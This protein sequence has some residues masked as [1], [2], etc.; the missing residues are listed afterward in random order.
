MSR[1]QKILVG[2]FIALLAG[3]VYVEATA[4]QPINWFPSYAKEDKI[5]LGGFV[6]DRLLKESFGDN[7]REIKTPPFETLQEH[8]FSGSYLFVNDEIDFDKTERDS[9][10][11]W[12]AKGNTVFVSAN[13]L[14]SSLLDTLNLKTETERNTAKLGTEPLLQ[15]SNKN[16]SEGKIYHIKKDLPLRYFS[17]IDTLNHTVLGVSGVYNKSLAIEKPRVNFIKVPL[18]KGVLFLH[19]Q[20]EAFSNFSLLS[21]DNA[22]YTSEVLSYIKGKTPINWDNYYKTGKRLDISPLRVLLNNKYFKW[23]YYFAL[24]GILLFIIFEGK[25]KQR[26]I[27]IVDPLSNKTYDFTRTIAGMYLDN[28][29]YH[30][31]AKKQILL[32]LEFIR[33]HLRVPTENLN[34]RFFQAV[35][36]R[37]GNSVEETMKLFALIKKIEVQNSIDKEE[38]ITLHMAISD[39]KNATTSVKESITEPTE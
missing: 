11:D 19:L 2:C 14:S 39:Y 38:L 12:V 26:S 17:K 22:Q 15:L 23:A 7:F 36:E 34:N 18:E 32:F 10:F 8:S 37:S 21:G 30:L 24:I 31:I 35:A 27:P 9:I 4:P 1:S 25:R 5:P 33:T 13:Y 3:L 20:P 6:I 16:I 28:N 29:E